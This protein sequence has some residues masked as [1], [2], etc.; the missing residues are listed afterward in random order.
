MQAVD[1]LPAELPREATEHFG[2][3]LMPLLP[4]LIASDG[5]KTLQEQQASCCCCS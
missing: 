3:N 4:N 1:T 2:D 5:S